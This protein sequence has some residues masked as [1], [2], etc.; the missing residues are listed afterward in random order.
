MDMEIFKKLGFSDKLAKIYLALLS[1]GPSSVRNLAE[2]CELNRGTTYDSLKWLQE[3]GLVNYY[4]KDTKQF[5][6]AE[7]P[8]KLQTLVK[9]QQ[10]E[11]SEASQKLE[12]TVPE[13][14]ALYNKGGERPVARYY[15]RKE[16]C[17]ILED[18]LT[19]CENSPSTDAQGK[20]ENLYRIYSAVGIREYLY[21]NFSTFSDARI[22]KNIAV[23]VIAIGEG[24]ELRGL[25]ERKWL[26]AEN[27][28]PTYIIIYPGKT[29]YISLD[30]KKEPIGVVIE[31]EGVFETQKIIF[32]NLWEK[33]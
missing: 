1:L 19:T 8:E 11:L 31:N 30:A 29:A 17:Q 5:F 28:N 6:V 3:K 23:K 12:K 13:L 21:D 33:L 22:G 24:G 16:I 20:S 10:V 2:N 26:K 32:D 15:E 27:A 7:D 25:D 4:Q 18:V 9:V 14:Q